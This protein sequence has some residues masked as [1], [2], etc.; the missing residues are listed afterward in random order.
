MLWGEQSYGNFLWLK[1]LTLA[2]NQKY[3]Y[4]KQIDHKAI[5]AITEISHYAF[6]AIGLTPFPQELPAQ[7]K[8]DY[9]VVAAYRDFILKIKP[10][11]PS[12][13][14]VHHQIGLLRSNT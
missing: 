2:I 6:P 14:N 13:L 7:Y 5:T 11:V 3:R 8:V 4:N 1:Q 10:N 12:G 9:E